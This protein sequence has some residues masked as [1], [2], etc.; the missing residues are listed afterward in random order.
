M[1]EICSRS[2][3]VE[4]YR[5]IVDNQ[6]GHSLVLDLPREQEGD[7]TGPT[8]LELCV[9]S[10]AGCISTIYA[11]TANK[12]RMPI[13]YLEVIIEA[14]KNPEIGTIGKVKTLVRVKTSAP[15]ERA[16]KALEITLRNCP[17]GILF[18][19]AGVEAEYSIELIK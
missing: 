2:I 4:K 3:L 6:R 14:E 8:A 1:T 9:M 16:K 5:S 18:K 12:M 19:R 11:V 10:L 13:E 7:D 17:V 15:E